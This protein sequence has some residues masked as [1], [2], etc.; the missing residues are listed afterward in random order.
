VV[1]MERAFGFPDV[2]REYDHVRTDHAYGGML[3]LRHLVALGHRRI[4]INLNASVTAY[5][6]RQGIEQAASS[7]GVELF[8]SPV[9]LPARGEDPTTLAQLDAFLAE[10]ESFGAHAVLVHSDE[11]AARLVERAMERGL[12]IPDDLAVIAYNDETAAMAVV[13]LTA[14][15][16]P[17]LMLGEA[18]CELL[19]RKL[20]VVP[21]MPR[22][23]Q[24]VSL[25]PELRVRQSCGAALADRF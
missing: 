4:G 24:H 2:E 18:A 12:R 6:L 16:P 23:I 10:C 17:K 11:H 25:L 8:V 9:A 21:G 3:A 13:P 1:L 19:L 14:V 22:S 7:L 5:W 15:C 20:K